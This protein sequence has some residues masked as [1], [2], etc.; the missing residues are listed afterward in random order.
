MNNLCAE[1][2]R[3]GVSI[4]DVSSILGCTNRTVK[5]KLEG[6]TNFNVEEAIKIRDKFFYG[7][8]IEYLFARTDIIQP[9]DAKSST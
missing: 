7:M 3:Y 5:N 1:M 6:L 8:R 2:A 4:S 9:D